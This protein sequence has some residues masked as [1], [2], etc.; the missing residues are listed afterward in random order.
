[1]Q[2]AEA[3]RYL[4]ERSNYE[5]TG[6]VDSPSTHNIDQLM[7]AIANPQHAYRSIHITGTNG[8]GSTAQIT[9]KLLMAHGLRVGTYSSPHLDRINDR[10]CIDGEPISDEEFGLQI[11]A[12]SDLEV[13][14]GVRP[15]FFEIMTAAMFRWFA[16]EAVDVA[17]IEVGML[18]RW[19][20]TNVIN[21]DVAVITNIALDHTEYAGPTVEHIATEKAGIIKPSSIVVLGE[22][23]EILREIFLKPN[24]RA[25][26]LRGDDFDCEDNRLAVG[27]RLISVRS[28]R[29]V[30][31]DILVPLHG[32][33]Q[34][35]NASLAICAVEAFFDAI[36]DR[37]I[38][39]AALESVVMPGRFEVLAHQPLVIVDG[40]HNP[41]G[42]KV[43][44]EVFFEDFNM[45]GRKILVTGALR[46]RDPDELLT[47]FRANEFDVVITCTPPS[48]R[49]L[50]AEEMAEV[51]RRIGCAEVIVADSVES[52]CDLALKIAQSQDAVLVAGSLY[53]VSSAR[54]HLRRRVAK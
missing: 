21:S 23:D 42:A 22:T 39:D 25:R 43:C 40:A 18:G 14:A 16:D 19:D 49:G 2:Y 7:D 53:I 27:G 20:A 4:D 6:R 11:G 52:A 45:Q 31:E 36:I 8:K 51:A 54:P 5:R 30:Y 44:A 12:I 32:Q 15:S 37:Q 3:L 48:P 38:L 34:G 46:S 13:I 33:H 47:T 1:M 9:T 41:A 50:P 26:I 35:E 24:A 28:S 10:I 17:V 29:T